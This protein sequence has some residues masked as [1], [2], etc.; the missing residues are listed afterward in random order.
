MLLPRR[1]R[2]GPGGGGGPC[3]LSSSEGGGGRFCGREKRSRKKPQ[4]NVVDKLG[5]LPRS[6][7]AAG[8]PVSLTLTVPP[9]LVREGAALS[10]CGSRCLSRREAQ[11][12]RRE[13]KKFGSEMQWTM[14]NPQTIGPQTI[15]RCPSTTVDPPP[16]GSSEPKVAPNKQPRDSGGSVHESRER[17]SVHFRTTPGPWRKKVKQKESHSCSAC[18]WS[19]HAV[20]DR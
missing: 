1:R 3:R 20:H 14:V 8:T 9:L 15:G 18:A 12:S 17:S 7:V 11:N 6:Q 19:P 10:V 2:R 16:R 13:K 5:R 4:E